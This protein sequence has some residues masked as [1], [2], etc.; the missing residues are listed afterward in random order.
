MNCGPCGRRSR[1]IDRTTKGRPAKRPAE[2]LGSAE[3]SRLSPTV[4]AAESA[5]ES[6]PIESIT[7]G[8]TTPPMKPTLHGRGGGAALS[9]AVAHRLV[10]AIAG[11]SAVCT[12][13]FRP[14]SVTDA[15]FGMLASVAARFVESGTKTKARTGASVETRSTGPAL[16]SQ[17]GA[18]AATEAESVAGACT[19]FEESVAGAAFRR[20]H[21]APR[22]AKTTKVNARQ[23]FIRRNLDPSPPPS[24]S[25]TRAATSYDVSLERSPR[26]S[27]SYDPFGSL[28]V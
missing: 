17:V 18:F 1:Q 7:I 20:S 19:W 10:S 28:G 23:G 25:G 4:R 2:S 15:G 14:K 11:S 13:P 6:A 21:A 12:L 27:L 9:V 24:T 16:W 8:A 5:A 22:I 26:P 3:A